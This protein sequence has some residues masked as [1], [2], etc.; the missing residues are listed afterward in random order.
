LRTIKIE[1]NAPYYP[2]AAR[3]GRVNNNNNKKEAI[4]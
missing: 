2:N 1:C 4:T 3:D